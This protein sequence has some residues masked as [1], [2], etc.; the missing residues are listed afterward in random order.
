[1]KR[2]SEPRLVRAVEGFVSVAV[3]VTE[4]VPRPPWRGEASNPD[5][6]ISS[7]HGPLAVTSRRAVAPASLGSTIFSAES[8]RLGFSVLSSE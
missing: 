1:M 7:C 4:V 8:V 3:R 5:P 2:C 6:D